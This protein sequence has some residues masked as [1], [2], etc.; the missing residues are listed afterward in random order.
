MLGDIK[1]QPIVISVNSA[2]QVVTIE[3]DTDKLYA[4]LTGIFFS[5]PD[6]TVET[7]TISRLEIGGNEIFPDG[8]EIKMITATKDVAIDERYYKLNEPAK[9]ARLKTKYND[10]GMSGAYPYTVI[11]YLRLENDSQ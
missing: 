1:Y 5:I 7:S 2:N 3:A 4:N 6:E 11:L 9:G 10:S 8:Y